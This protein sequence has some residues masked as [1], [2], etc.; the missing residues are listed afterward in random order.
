MG[1]KRSERVRHVV[2]TE[3]YDEQAVGR[4]PRDF[5]VVDVCMQKLVFNLV[6]EALYSRSKARHYNRIIYR[7]SA[8]A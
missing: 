2:D 4:S 8:V 5:A 6:L 7:G 1:S 3:K